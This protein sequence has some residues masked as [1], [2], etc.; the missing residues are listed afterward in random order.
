M[1]FIRPLSSRC[2]NPNPSLIFNSDDPMRWT[3]WSGCVWGRRLNTGLW[4]LTFS[5]A[6]FRDFWTRL[7]RNPAPVWRFGP[8]FWLSAIV[9]F[10]QT[11]SSL[12]NLPT[13]KVCDECVSQQGGGGP[14]WA[15][16]HQATHPHR[17][18]PRPPGA[19][20]SETRPK[21]GLT[22]SSSSSPPVNSS[23]VGTCWSCGAI[24]VV[25]AVSFGWDLG[26]GLGFRI[27]RGEKM[28]GLSS[29]GQWHLVSQQISPNVMCS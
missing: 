1:G 8:V 3:W 18:S 22:S 16:S 6:R 25:S 27:D 10:S 24:V 29:M 14:R 17:A 15:R 2:P 7:A 19:F 21:V 28:V 5:W 4:S 11:P 26:F 23:R 9:M 13:R 20:C 12:W